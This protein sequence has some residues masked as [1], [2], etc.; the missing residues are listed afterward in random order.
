VVLFESQINL[1]SKT[2]YSNLHSYLLNGLNYC[3]FYWEF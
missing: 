1:K 2:N 3:V